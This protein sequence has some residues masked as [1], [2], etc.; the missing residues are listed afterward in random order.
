MYR[1]SRSQRHR[2]FRTAL[3]RHRQCQRGDVLPPPDL[4]LGPRLLRQ[5]PA[6]INTA[7][8]P[9]RRARRVARAAAIFP[10]TRGYSG[11]MR[12]VEELQITRD[13]AALVRD[14]EPAAKRTSSPA[15]WS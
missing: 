6:D 13:G 14:G 5:R 9:S 2:R 12:G 10:I 1:P 15:G 8:R 3:L 11:E 4:R 7:E